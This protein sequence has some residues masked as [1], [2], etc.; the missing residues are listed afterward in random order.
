MLS[1]ICLLYFRGELHF[2]TEA[3]NTLAFLDALIIRKFYNIL[4]RTFYRDTI[5]YHMDFN[6]SQLEITELAHLVI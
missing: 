4:G 3:N 5:P 1:P 6:I 2:I